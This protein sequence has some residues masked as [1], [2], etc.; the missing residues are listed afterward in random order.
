MSRTRIW[1]LI[2]GMYAQVDLRAQERRG[3]V[4]V[5]LDAV[6]RTGN[7]ARVFKVVD[8]DR[9]RATEVKLGIETAQVVEVLS[10][11]GVG[12]LV[13]VGRRSDIRDGQTVRAQADNAA[14]GGR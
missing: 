8:G 11:V 1:C 6:E 14:P 3:A 10:G 13:V 5:P 9:I 2:P 4:T 12:E 7:T